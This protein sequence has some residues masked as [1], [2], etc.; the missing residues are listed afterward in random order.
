VIK[1][2]SKPGGNERFFTVI[3]LI[4]TGLLKTIDKG[5]NLLYWRSGEIGKVNS[6]QVN[7]KRKGESR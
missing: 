6:Y 4:F 7:T 5:E 3:C 1:S 2:S